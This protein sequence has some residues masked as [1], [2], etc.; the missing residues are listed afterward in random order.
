MNKYW[1]SILYVIFV[2][3]NSCK[4]NN[5]NNNNEIVNIAGM[6]LVLPDTMLRYDN[7]Y[8]TLA[9]TETHKIDKDR[10]II[11]IDSTK[12]STCYLDYLYNYEVVNDYIRDS[13]CNQIEIMMLIT[14]KRNELENLLFKI[15]NHNFDY[16]INIDYN[17]EMYN[18]LH[19]TVNNDAIM[20]L[21]SDK[22]GKIKSGIYNY[23]QY[24]DMCVM[25]CIKY[26]NGFILQD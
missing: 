3:T 8:N 20:V 21:L 16:P 25:S 1:L 11:W 7:N 5:L 23:P 12:C 2:L 15:Q 6:N 17:Q 19:L 18:D 9:K 10:M 24:V 26:L 22:N 13:L 4:N 14:P